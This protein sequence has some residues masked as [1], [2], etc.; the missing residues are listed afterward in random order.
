MAFDDILTR[1]GDFSRF[2]YMQWFLLFLSSITQAWYSYLPFFT[3]AKVKDAD[4]VCT[5]NLNITGC[6]ANCS[7]VKYAVDYT[8][9]VTEV[10][11]INSYKNERQSTTLPQIGSHNISPLIYEINI[12]VLD[13]GQQ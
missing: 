11:Y 9:I 6:N 4:V 2:Q 7:S 12:A 3:A 10:N 8:S 1:V 5:S 13:L